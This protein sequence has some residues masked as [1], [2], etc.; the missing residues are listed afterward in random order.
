MIIKTSPMVNKLHIVHHWGC[1]NNNTG[2]QKKF[3]WCRRCFNCFNPILGRWLQNCSQF[4]SIRSSF[5]A[6]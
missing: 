6:V 2:R 3:S 4:F 5:P 1:Y